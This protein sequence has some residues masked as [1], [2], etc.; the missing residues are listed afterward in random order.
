MISGFVCSAE[1]GGKLC[2]SSF[3][4]LCMKNLVEIVTD[5]D[6]KNLHYIYGRNYV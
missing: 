4:R 5:F 3:L 6:N 2:V 1:A